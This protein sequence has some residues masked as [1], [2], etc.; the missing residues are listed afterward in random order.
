MLLDQ[1][2]RAQHRSE[3]AQRRHLA[4]LVAFNRLTGGLDPEQVEAGTEPL[5]RAPSATHQPLRAGLRSH[6]GEDALADRLRH[7]GG[8]PLLSRTERL[9]QLQGQPLRLDVLGHLAQADLAQR[10]QVLDPE[11]VVQRRVDVLAGVDLAGA[12]TLDQGLGGEVDQHH[13]V[14]RAEHRV[15]HGLPHPHPGQLR[16]PVVERLEVLDVEGRVNVDPGRQHVSDVLVALAVLESRRVAVGKLVDQRQ[17]RVASQD[18]RQVH[19]LDLD[20]AVGNPAPGDDLQP[21]GLVAG[22]LAFVRLQVADRDIA[23]GLPLGPAL[24]Q[25]AV[26]LPHPGRHAEEDL[27]VAAVHARRPP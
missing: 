11:E 13:F 24:L 18:P 4:L 8:D 2:G 27:V 3:L 21:D 5:C 9:V 15:R 26:G 20:L 12:Q 14:G 23:P 6:Q 16:H 22:L 25:H 10:R 7:L 19:L 1:Q 17:L